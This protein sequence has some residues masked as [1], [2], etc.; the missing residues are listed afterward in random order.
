MN[1]HAPEAPPVFSPAMAGISI[2]VDESWGSLGADKVQGGRESLR[3]K[4][5]AV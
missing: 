4:R 1:T 3:L 5:V 2:D